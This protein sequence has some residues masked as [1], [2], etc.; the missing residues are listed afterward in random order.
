MQTLQLLEP[1]PSESA[2]GEDSAAE[3][4]TEPNVQ[5]GAQEPP[6]RGSSDGPISS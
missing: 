5:A 6:A 1:H 4:L 3:V 2:S